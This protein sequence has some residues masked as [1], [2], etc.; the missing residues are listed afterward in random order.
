MFLVEFIKRIQY[1]KKADRIGPD[2]F[3]THWRLHF[4]STMLK[5]CQQKFKHFDPT[6]EFRPGACAIACSNISIGRRVVVRYGCF[7]E[8]DPRPGQEGI[9]IQ[10]DVLLSPHVRII[11][12]N[13]SF[14]DTD[15]PIMDQPT[16]PS[17]K[18]TIKR[19][20]WI[21]A[22][23]IILPGVTIGENCV[24]GAGAVV[25]KSIPDYSVAIGVPARVVKRLR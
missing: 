2:I 12:N 25:T 5:L 16:D 21:G 11:V 3:W 1:C 7:I 23:V 14:K 13:H 4:K 9:E 8:S 15:K 19:G 10:D 17:K 24:I 20:A 22:D 18:I 6:A